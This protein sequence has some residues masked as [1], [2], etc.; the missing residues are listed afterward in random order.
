MSKIYWQVDENNIL[1]YVITFK[2]S[3]KYLCKTPTQ[4]NIICLVYIN[5]YSFLK[6][7]KNFIYY[8]TYTIIQDSLL[9]NIINYTKYNINIML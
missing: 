8:K 6:K 3:Y 1:S 5:F 7:I 4:T 9:Y 2:K